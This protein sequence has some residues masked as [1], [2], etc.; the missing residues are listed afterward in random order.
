MIDRPT[1]IALGLNPRRLSRATR[2]QSVLPFAHPKIRAAV[3]PPAAQPQKTAAK[4]GGQPSA[5]V[6]V[7]PDAGKD[8]F[9]VKSWNTSRPIGKKGQSNVSH[10]E[11]QF[12]EWFTSRPWKW[13]QRVAAVTVTVEGLPVCPLCDADLKAMK[14]QNPNIKE[15]NLPGMSPEQGPNTVVAKD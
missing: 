7:A 12:T 3:L 13:R 6:I 8:E 4:K 15:W 1:G 11:H 14:A 9:Q 10:A 5:G 2:V